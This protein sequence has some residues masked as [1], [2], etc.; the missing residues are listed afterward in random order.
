LLGADPRFETAVEPE[1]NIVCFR[2]LSKG[3][4]GE[5]SDELHQKVRADVIASGDFYLVQTVLGGRVWLRTALM[6][7]FTGEAHLRPLIEAVVESAK[8]AVST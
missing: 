1:S 3:I 6:N 2:L 5:E 4:D 8:R 7:P